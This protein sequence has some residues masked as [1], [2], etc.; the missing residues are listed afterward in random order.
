MPTSK[1]ADVNLD[2]GASAL[3][4]QRIPGQ[5]VMAQLLAVHEP[6]RSGLRRFFGASPLSPD[7][8]PWYLGAEG[9]REV[10]AILARRLGQDWT[11]LHAV[12]VGTGDSDIDHVV[13]GPP[14]VFTINTKN[15]AGKSV[16]VAGRTL[17]VSGHKQNHIRNSIHEAARAGKLLSAATEFPV[18]VT[19]V[20]ALVGVKSLTIKVAA[21]G[22]T[23]LTAAQLPRWL[24][25]RPPALSEDAVVRIAAAAKQPRTWHPTHQETDRP[26]DILSSFKNIQKSVQSARRR[27]VAW[28]FATLAA[29]L[30]VGFAAAPLAPVLIK[31]VTHALVP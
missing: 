21:D 3:L 19:G 17:M 24:S 11:V 4:E 8:R 14:G 29:T 5:S 6:S 31:I 7:S 16:W 20:I 12:P 18:T 27:R 25:K 30:A 15:H 9:E 28:G 22:A 13:I 26:E 10:G 1:E 23:V 2:S